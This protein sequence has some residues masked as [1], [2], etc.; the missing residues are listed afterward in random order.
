MEKRWIRKDG[1]VIYSTISVKCVRRQDGAVDYFM[2]LLQ[3]ITA[4]KQAE[5]AL[6]RSHGNLKRRVADRT[7]RTH[8]DQRG[9]AKRDRR[10]QAGTR[11]AATQRGLPC[12]GAKNQPRG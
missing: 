9:T 2:A 12:R 1:R 5:E 3:D 4:R 11:G 10:A 8:G 6:A 7:A